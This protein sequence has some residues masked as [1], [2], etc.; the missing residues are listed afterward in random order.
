MIRSDRHGGAWGL[1]WAT[2]ALAIPLRV[3]FFA[4]YGLGDDYI[5]VEPVLRLLDTGEVNFADYRTNRPLL[6]LSQILPFLVLPVDDYSFVLPMFVFSLATHAASLFFA[7]ALLN[8]RAALFTSLFFLT[9]PFET[10]TATAFSP[11]NM[12]GCYGVVCAWMCYRGCTKRDARAMIAGGLALVA[13]LLTKIAAVLMIPVLAVATVVT[14]RWWRGW[15]AFWTTVTVGVAATSL[16]FWLVAGEPVQRFTEEQLWGHDVTHMLWTVWSKYPRYVLWRDPEFGRWLFGWSGLVG[17]GGLCAATGA[18]IGGR[19]SRQSVVVALFL[20]YVL[21]FNF[22]P[23]KLDLAAYYSHP[24]I[25]RYLAQVAPFLHIAAAYLCD[26]AWRRG[27]GGR[28]AAGLTVAVVAGFGLWETPAATEPSWDANGDGRAL[29]AFF[30]HTVPE[31][32]VAIHG[33]EWNCYRLRYMNHGQARRW[34]FDCE[35]FE[36]EQQKTAFL[37]DIDHGYVVTGG[38]SLAWY[39]NHPWVLN[40]GELGFAPPP[41]WEQ[42]LHV[43]RPVRPWRREPMRVWKVRDALSDA[44]VRIADP[45]FERCLRERVTPLRPEDGLPPTQP[46]T[47]RLARFV[48]AIE[49][50]NMGIRHLGGV[51]KFVD[52][53][54]LNAAGNALDRVDVGALTNLTVLV[55]GANRL[56]RI[57]GTAGLEKLRLLWLGHNRLQTIDVSGLVNLE[58]LRVDDNRLVGMTGAEDL[59]KLERL[60]LGQNPDLDCGALRLPKAL[61]EASGCRGVR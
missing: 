55:L 25:F 27:R 1:A 19:P 35:W 28:I 29:S 13:A 17:L 43:D 22:V 7:R 23:H 47:E 60:F 10:L 33:D 30:R 38:A 5:F 2:F 24:R 53:E 42:V 11:D 51:E 14:W 9:T 49:C 48:T 21:L 18:V 41:A 54:V 26:L 56:Q 39:S 16:G 45:L 36:D 46:I 15:L 8:D 40:L 31:T 20:L 58:D 37:A 61:I 3:Y 32:P 52:V 6:I 50:P 12:L 57:D 59:A 44:P 34:R 4:G